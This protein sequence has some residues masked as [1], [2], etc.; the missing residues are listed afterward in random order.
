MSDNRENLVLSLNKRGGCNM[1]KPLRILLVAA[2]VLVCGL[3]VNSVMAQ[4]KKL[5]VSDVVAFSHPAVQAYLFRE[6]A[7]QN[8][9]FNKAWELTL[10]S[11]RKNR[12]NGDI[13]AFK[14]NYSE[15]P[16]KLTDKYISIKQANLINPKEVKI[17]LVSGQIYVMSQENG[18]WY[19][20]GNIEDVGGK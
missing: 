14:K 18:K 6:K 3:F 15:N 17:E 19:W 16:D 1:K 8:K 13:E 20:A 4:E 12:F 2:G 10:E 5:P 7:F 9:D 11:V